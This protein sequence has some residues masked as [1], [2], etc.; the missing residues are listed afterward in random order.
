M[1]ILIA[2]LIK[3]RQPLDRERTDT[4]NITVRAVDV[5]R[6]NVHADVMVTVSFILHT[7][8]S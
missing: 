2:G 1:H 4:Y 5:S 7:E 8:L 6:M 3:V